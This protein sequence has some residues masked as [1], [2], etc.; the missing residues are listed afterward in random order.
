MT[1]DQFRKSIQRA[2]DG[3]VWHSYIS[4]GKP[5][6]TKDESLFDMFADIKNMGSRDLENLVL[7]NYV[8]C[9][10]LIN[11]AW[12]ALH[13]KNDPAFS[14]NFLMPGIRRMANIEVLLNHQIPLRESTAQAL[15]LNPEF[16]SQIF[17]DMIMKTKKDTAS[18]S[19]VLEKMELYLKDRL[20]V[21]VQPILRILEKETELVHYD[22]MTNDEKI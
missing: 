19:T 11:K 12:K 18:L 9:K 7:L 6:F 21:I 8:F 3:S 13:V 10:D 5:I 15:E 2:T 1:R 22:L 4:M 20:E 16:F 14:V 17:T